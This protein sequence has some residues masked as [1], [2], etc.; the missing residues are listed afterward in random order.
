MFEEA[1]VYALRR[2]GGKTRTRDRRRLRL[3]EFGVSVCDRIGRVFSY[4]TS[5][6]GLVCSTRWRRN[7]AH[8]QAAFVNTCGAYVAAEK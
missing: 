7:S 8:G 4:L 5:F 6:A 3:L 1:Q 2:R